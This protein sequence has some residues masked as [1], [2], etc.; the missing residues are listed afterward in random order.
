MLVKLKHHW[1]H[2]KDTQFFC[3]NH[4]WV[5]FQG[6]AEAYNDT[7]QL[8]KETGTQVYILGVSVGCLGG[9]GFSGVAKCVGIWEG[10][11]GF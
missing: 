2:Q 10:R 7:F 1:L 3:S 5:S 9:V 6:F 4:S 8:P 11:V